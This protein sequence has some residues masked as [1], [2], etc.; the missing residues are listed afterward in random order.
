MR[1]TETVRWLRFP[2]DKDGTRGDAFVVVLS[3]R[4]AA[5]EYRDG[6][7][8]L[9]HTQGEL[10][11]FE[12][13]GHFLRTRFVRLAPSTEAGRR[14]RDAQLGAKLAAEFLGIEVAEPAPVP[15]IVARLRELADALAGLELPEHEYASVQLLFEDVTALDATSFATAL[16]KQTAGSYLETSP[17][18]VAVHVPGRDAEACVELAFPEAP[19]GA[20]ADTDLAGL[21]AS[22]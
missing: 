8:R 16:L 11:Y 20:P 5:N 9:V 19:A 21:G 15:P 12:V 22:S 17:S 3:E 7:L 6:C 18:M 1:S 13:G 4:D 2:V 10:T 14:E